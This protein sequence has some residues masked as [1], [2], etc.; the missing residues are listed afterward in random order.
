MRSDARSA[1]GGGGR[2]QDKTATAVNG[3]THKLSH[4]DTMSRILDPISSW[5]VA[6]RGAGGGR[7]IEPMRVVKTQRDCLKRWIWLMR[8]CMV[9]SRPKEGMRPV[10]KLFRCSNDIITQKVYFS[11]LMRVCI[12]L[13]G[14]HLI[15]VLC[16]I[17]SEGFG[18]FLH[19]SVLASHWLE[20]C[21][22]F[23]LTPDETKQESRQST[24]INKQLYST[25]DWQKGQK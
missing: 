12:G 8:T 3:Q 9:S 17:W 4:H 18:R 15:Q 1:V 14:L 22:N 24:F 23:T 20:D 13:S 21:A 10:L 16:F 6:G 25:C 2:G 11:R 7:R 19:V 5:L